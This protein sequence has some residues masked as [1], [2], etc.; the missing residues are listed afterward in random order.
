M[1]EVTRQLRV[2]FSREEIKGILAERA[3]ALVL[4]RKEIPCVELTQVEDVESAATVILIVGNKPIEV[5]ERDK[6]LNARTALLEEVKDL[7][8]QIEGRK[9]FDREIP[10]LQAR[11]K[12][13]RKRRT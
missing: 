7:T 12:A 5:T 11:K 9:P 2:E 1:A 8:D 4:A 6:L 10:K 13:S 3:K